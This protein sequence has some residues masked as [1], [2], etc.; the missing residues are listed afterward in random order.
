MGY[1]SLTSLAQYGQIE[2]QQTAIQQLDQAISH[3]KPMLWDY[4]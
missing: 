3:E 4:F 2:G 1:R